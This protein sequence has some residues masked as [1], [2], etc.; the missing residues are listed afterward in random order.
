[1]A[2]RPIPRLYQ[3]GTTVCCEAAAIMAS[4]LSARLGDF[5]YEQIFRQDY[6][7]ID[8]ACTTHSSHT[9]TMK[10]YR[11]D[12]LCREN[13]YRSQQQCDDICTLLSTSE[14]REF[15][16]NTTLELIHAYLPG[17]IRTVALSTPGFDEVM[18]QQTIELEN[19]VTASLCKRS[20]V[21]W[22][23]IESCRYLL[24]LPADVHALL[25]DHSGAL[26]AA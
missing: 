21:S 6:L 4:P 22:I 11:L 14:S 15:S 7:I 10:W 8:D 25:I 9:G 13:G 12:Q 2:D 19:A 5:L 23:D 1:M 26:L 17:C 24:C 20:V 18:S 3:W 16:T